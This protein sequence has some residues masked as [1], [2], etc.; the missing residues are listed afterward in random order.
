MQN[1][2]IG[3]LQNDLGVEVRVETRLGRITVQ[4]LIE[5]VMSA[6]DKINN[7]IRKA[8]AIQQEKQAAEMI[9]NMVEWCFLDTSSVPPKLEKYPSHINL[10]LEKA[11]RNQDASTAFKDSDGNEYIVD[12]TAYEEYPKGDRKDVVKVIRKSKIDGLYMIIVIKNK[13][14]YISNLTGFF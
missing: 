5:D 14:F 8:D 10:Q 9:A 2:E 4:G 12:L 3:K 6:S 7:M 1:I 11:L 13:L